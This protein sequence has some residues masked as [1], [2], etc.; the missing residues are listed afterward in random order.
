MPNRSKQVS[1]LRSYLFMALLHLIRVGGLGGGSFLLVKIAGLTPYFFLNRS[2][3][4]TTDTELNAIATEAMMGLRRMWK[5][6]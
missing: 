6:G 1:T 4:D 3:F 5:N 2:E